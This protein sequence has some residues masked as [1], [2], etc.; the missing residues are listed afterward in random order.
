MLELH[1]TVQLSLQPTA[2]SC[3]SPGANVKGAAFHLRADPDAFSFYSSSF[4]D[5]TCLHAP[6]PTPLSFCMHVFKGA[7]AYF[8]CALLFYPRSAASPVTSPL[9]LC[10][11]FFITGLFLIPECKISQTKLGQKKVL[12][13]QPILSLQAFWCTA[14]FYAPV[15]YAWEMS[16]YLENT[17]IKI[18]Y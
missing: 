12:F 3:R 9:S 14:T 11:C 8:P 6:T 13:R 16:N 7:G 15:L 2:E 17:T 1:R 18:Q 10:E 4:W 5:V